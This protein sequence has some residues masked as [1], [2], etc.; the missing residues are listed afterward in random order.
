MLHVLRLRG[1]DGEPGLLE[2]TVYA[3][4]IAPAGE[5]IE[6][7]RPSVTRRLPDDT[8]P[9]FAYGEHVIDAVAAGARDAELPGIRLTSPPLRVRRC[10][11]AG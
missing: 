7:D 1:P 9:A 8:G 6:P 4:R 3:D 5:P 2:R 11:S 10:G